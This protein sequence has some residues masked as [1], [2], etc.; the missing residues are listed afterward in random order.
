M[1]RQNQ[2][3]Q[4]FASWIRRGRWEPLLY[5]FNQNESKGED[6]R[7]LAGQALALDFPTQWPHYVDFFQKHMDYKLG[8]YV[9]IT[10][11]DAQTKAWNVVSIALKSF[12]NTAVTSL[13]GPQKAAFGAAMFPLLLKWKPTSFPGTG[14]PVHLNFI[15]PYLELA[16]NLGA[17]QEWD[18]IRPLLHR[19]DTTNL[20]G[21]TRGQDRLWAD[22]LAQ[23]YFEYG[24]EQSLWR[25]TLLTSDCVEHL[26]GGGDFPV[27][28]AL[29]EHGLFEG[30]RRTMGPTEYFSW[31]HRRYPYLRVWCEHSRSDDAQVCRALFELPE[32]VS[33]RH[34]FAQSISIGKSLGLGLAALVPLLNDS[35]P[36][37]VD[38]LGDGTLFEDAPGQ[39]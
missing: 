28:N 4:Q 30:T 6:W 34:H 7:T 37:A 12:F 27:A 14:L 38:M 29:L 1:S 5:W 18:N 24:G 26:Q 15:G 2:I 3:Q 10:V 23:V 31:M 11:H 9:G 17:T 8:A 20:I 35:L 36:T 16:M 25:R 13:D 39:K 33:P 32:M 21:S 22:R 19:D